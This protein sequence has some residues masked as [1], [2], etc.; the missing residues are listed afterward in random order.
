MCT[1]GLLVSYSGGYKIVWPMVYVRT[2]TDKTH[3]TILT[4]LFA[5]VQET[6]IL[7]C[8]I[9][10]P[11]LTLLELPLSSSLHF[12]VAL[13][14][15]ELLKVPRLRKAL[16]VCHTRGRELARD[17]KYKLNFSH[18]VQETSRRM[19]QSEGEEDEDNVASATIRA[20]L[21]ATETY[22]YI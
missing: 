5:L 12:Q 1:K 17:I 2:T 13:N 7:A 6:S 20:R 10:G 4:C 18:R 3:D 9:D 8:T 11:C 21:V 16:E 15:D 22:V 14:R 19:M